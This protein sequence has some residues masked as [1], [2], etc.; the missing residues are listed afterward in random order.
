M[1]LALAII[2]L[3]DDGELDCD[4]VILDDNLTLH[5]HDGQD[6]RI[7]AETIRDR[8]L[9]VKIVGY[10]LGKMAAY[11]VPVD[12]GKQNIHTLRTVLDKL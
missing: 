3:I 4:I 9:P 2:E 7:L 12:V 1:T 11:G 10:S 6:G 5:A 8:A